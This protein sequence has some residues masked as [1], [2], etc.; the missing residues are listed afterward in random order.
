MDAFSGY[1]QICMSEEDQEKTAFVTSQGLNNHQPGAVLLQGHVVRFEEC[2]GNLSEA[3]E[4][5]VQQADWTEY[6]S[7]CGRHAHEKQKRRV[8]SGQPQRNF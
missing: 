7:V 2:K 6:G 5:N 3:G 4:L 8:T 1:N